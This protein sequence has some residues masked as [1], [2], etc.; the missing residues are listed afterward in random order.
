MEILDIAIK[1][2]KGVGKLAKALGV[3]QNVVS[4]WKW[5]GKL[6][7]PWELVLKTKY[8]RA[9]KAAKQKG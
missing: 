2:A 7:K 8:A 4:N 9:I 1:S 5:R 6:P 3:E